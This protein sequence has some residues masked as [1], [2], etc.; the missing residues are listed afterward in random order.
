MQNAARLSSLQQQLQEL[1][2]QR[3]AALGSIDKRQVEEAVQQAHPELTYVSLRRRGT[4]LELFV[5]EATDPPEIFDR[6]QPVDV[7]AGSAGLIVGV[8]V[9]SGTALVQPGDTVRQG[10]VLIQGVDHNGNPCHASGQVT[11]R[12][13]HRRRGPGRPVS[14]TAP[15]DRQAVYGNSPKRLGL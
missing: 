9:F 8:T 11:A 7:V 2:V 13:W 10:Q 3:G 15:S 1:G 12:L 14:G 4:S 6:N 5:V